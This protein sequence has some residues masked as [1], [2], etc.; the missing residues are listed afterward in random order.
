[1]RLS[2]PLATLA[3]TLTLTAG[4]T[5]V[6][7]VASASTHSAT[8]VTAR[9]GGHDGKSTQPRQRRFELKGTITAVDAD[10]HT[11][12]VE[13]RVK[14]HGRSKLKLTKTVDLVIAADATIRLNG[15]A[16][17]EGDLQVGDRVKLKGLVQKNDDGTRTLVVTR[18]RACGPR[19][20]PDPATT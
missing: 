1:M 9:H 15:A 7:S 14:R 18:I 17:E 16:A 10:E 2:R 19:D 4:L 8:H 5:A 6:P 11:M 13:V 20:T 3:V 12:T